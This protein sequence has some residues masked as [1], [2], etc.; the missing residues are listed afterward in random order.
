[1]QRTNQRRASLIGVVDD[2]S[3]L[4]VGT[5]RHRPAHG[6][7]IVNPIGLRLVRVPA[8]EFL[9]GSHEPTTAIK[10]AFPDD[11]PEPSYFNDETPQHPV[12]ITRPFWMGQTEVTVGQFRR[13]VEATDYRTEA[14]S[15][16]EGGWGF[17]RSTRRCEGRRP[18]FTWR[19]PG[20][21]QSDQH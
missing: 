13:F 8:G 7:T 1:M 4:L 19:D 16:G 3:P 9:M 14:E 6:A 11:S 15:D 20:F 17:N 21:P 10:A 18:H 5:E 12:R 2:M